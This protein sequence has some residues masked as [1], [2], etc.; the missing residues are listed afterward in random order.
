MLWPSWRA[1]DGS[2]GK[3]VAI[4]SVMAPALDSL[5]QPLFDWYVQ[6]KIV[7]GAR[8]DEEIRHIGAA[9]VAAVHDNVT[10]AFGGHGI[11][12][13][14]LSRY[15]QA[16]FLGALKIAQREPAHKIYAAAIVDLVRLLRTKYPRIP[17]M[18]ASYSSAD[19]S[20][21]EQHEFAKLD[22]P[23]A[24]LNGDILKTAK[25]YD[26]IVNAWDPHSFPGNGN[27]NDDSLD[28]FLGRA[29]TILLTQLPHFNHDIA[30]V[31]PIQ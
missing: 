11:E 26:F 20:Q 24:Y 31:G 7:H 5:N 23:L 6:D 4:L 30:Y 9:I 14:L 21:S 22:P 28:G 13:I 16:A 1:G 25:S 29:S 12:R 2:G 19:L 27:D 17:I 8:Y 18:L 10:T 3:K 15:G